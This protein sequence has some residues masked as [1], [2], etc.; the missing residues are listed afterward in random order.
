MA[1][2]RRAEEAAPA[3]AV[4]GGGWHIV[5]D[6]EQVGPIPEADVRARIERGEI[7]ADTYTWKEGFADWLK[8]SAVPEFADAVGGDSGSVA[9]RTFRGHCARAPTNGTVA[10]GAASRARSR[11]C[12]AAARGDDVV[13]VAGGGRAAAAICSRSA[14][15]RAAAAEPR[16]PSSGGGGAP[17]VARRRPR[18]EPDRPAARELGAVLALEPA[19]AGD[20]E[21]AAARPRRA[22]VRRRTPDGSGLIDI[23]AMAATTAVALPRRARRRQPLDDDLP[24]L[25]FVRSGS[26]VLLPLQTAA[27]RSGSTR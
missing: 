27:R 16:W 15:R 10:R 7:K 11:R 19:V 21:H 23:R 9:R 6:G 22:A 8:L 18:R 20:V 12:S 17:R 13:L 5:V 24:V 1:A 25:R 26:A 2:S 14:A 4:E 3:P